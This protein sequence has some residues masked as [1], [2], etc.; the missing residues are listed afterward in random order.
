MIVNNLNS[1]GNPASFDIFTFFVSSRLKSEPTGNIY[2]RE[3][4]REGTRF[5]C[6]QICPDFPQYFNATPTCK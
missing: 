5:Y 1:E 6:K 2:E 4:E 3:R